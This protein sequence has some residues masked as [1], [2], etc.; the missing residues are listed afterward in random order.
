MSHFRIKQNPNLVLGHD[1]AQDFCNEGI[2]VT[3]YVSFNDPISYLM[4]Y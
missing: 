2:D 3:M 1:I 4:Y